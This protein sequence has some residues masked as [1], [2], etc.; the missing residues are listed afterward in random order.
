MVLSPSP[1]ESG[2]TDSCRNGT[3]SLDMQLVL[4]SWD[5]LSG[6][7]QDKCRG[8]QSDVFVEPAVQGDRGVSCLTLE[9]SPPPLPTAWQAP[10]TPPSLHHSR[11]GSAR[12][13]KP[14]PS[15][16]S[17]SPVSCPHLRSSQAPA[18]AR[19]LLS[20]FHDEHPGWERWDQQG[21]VRPSHAQGH[22]GLMGPQPALPLH[23]DPSQAC[24]WE[25]VGEPT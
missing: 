16:P 1:A 24:H 13:R 25:A 23:G 3:E 14:Q 9:G 21:K 18:L 22:S 20:P 15:Y 4:E 10:E 5:S 8:R 17:S 6:T 2:L 19:L 7:M 11:K 12:S